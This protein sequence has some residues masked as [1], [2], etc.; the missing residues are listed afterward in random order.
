MRTPW[1]V[2]VVLGLVVV[3][4]CAPKR[5]A[6]TGPRLVGERV[7]VVEF[8]TEGARV[9]YAGPHEAMGL[10]LASEI[11]IELRRLGHTAEAVTAA[12]APDGTVVV[13][14]RIYRI[15]EGSRSTRFWVG[16]GA[17][18]A[19]FGAEGDVTRA[20]GTPIGAFRDQ[21]GSSGMADA[22]GGSGQT[23]LQKCLT[24]VGR[25]IARMIDKGEYRR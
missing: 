11:A 2:G 20:D 14:G 17:G 16:F 8:A 7:S 23:L 5:P 12:K 21:R 22:W 13:R 24:V 25:D 10:Q 3:A 15:E 18:A 6:V 9:N 1:A 19:E 4:A